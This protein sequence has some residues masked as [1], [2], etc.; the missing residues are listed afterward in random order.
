MRFV[1]LLSLSAIEVITPSRKSRKP[2][3]AIASNIVSEIVMMPSFNPD[4]LTIIAW[5]RE[6]LGRGRSPLPY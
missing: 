5:G 6:I 2:P 4:L 3:I 1:R